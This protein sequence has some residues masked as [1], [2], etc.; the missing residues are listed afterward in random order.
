MHDKIPQKGVIRHKGLIFK[1]W[2]RLHIFGSTLV[3]SQI[4][5]TD[6]KLALKGAGSGSHDPFKN[7]CDRRYTRLGIYT[8]IVNI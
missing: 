5:A 6:E 7:C 2:D 8:L 1:S 4:A 3:I